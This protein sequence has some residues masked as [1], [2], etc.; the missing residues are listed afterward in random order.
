MCCASGQA[1][2][3]AMSQLD[4]LDYG[5]IRSPNVLCL[6]NTDRFGTKH[7]FVSGQ[8]VAIHVAHGDWVVTKSPKLPNKAHSLTRYKTMGCTS[9]L[10]SVFSIPTI[11]YATIFDSRLQAKSNKYTLR[12]L[13][14]AHSNWHSDATSHLFVGQFSSQPQLDFKATAT[15]LR[16]KHIRCFC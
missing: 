1:G 3:A 9:S 16:F 5:T 14:D 13:G 8:F 10:V 6:C 2:L 4:S 11:K 12:C 15:S 7:L